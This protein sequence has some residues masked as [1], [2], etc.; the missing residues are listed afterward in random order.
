MSENAGRSASAVYH[1]L[2]SRTQT[3]AHDQ[4][5]VSSG[6]VCGRAGWGSHIPS[7]KAYPGPLPTG[8]SGIEFTTHVALS[9]GR[10][11]LSMVKWYQGD[12]GVI[13]SGTGLVCIPVT[14]LRVV[15]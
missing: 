9:A 3:P 12:P 7:V 11:S 8:A 15:P 13:N 10:S 4:M 14:I 2:R 1:R 5:Q 6:Q